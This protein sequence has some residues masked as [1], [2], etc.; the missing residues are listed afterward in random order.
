MSGRIRFGLYELD[1]DARELRKRGVLIRLQDQPFRVLA[2]LTARPGEIVTREEL[3]EQIWGKE[4]FVDFD[5]SL[6][7][8]VNRIREAL[9]DDANT[10]QY[11]ETVPRRGYRF[12][13]SVEGRGKDDVPIGQISA[14]TS[15]AIGYGTT[16]LE[17]EPPQT[18]TTVA[19]DVA[20][21]S[22]AVWRVAIVTIASILVA[23]LILGIW[24]VFPTP[25]PRIMKSMQLTNDGLPKCCPLVTDG[26]RI[27]FTEKDP[28]RVYS[29]IEQIQV[30]G[31]D[32]TAIPVPALK[33]SLG[34]NDIS[35]DRDRLLVAA[36]ISGMEVALWSVPVSG[37]SPRAL[38]DVPGGPGFN[39]GRWS[40]DG[41]RLVY[42]NGADLNVAQSD[43]SEP[44]RLV[45]VKGAVSDPVWSPD[46][47]SVRF[48]AKE[49]ET[50]DVGT[51][52]EVSAEGGEPREVTPG[53]QNKSSECAGN[54]T[55]DGKYF[56]FLTGCGRRTDIWAVREKRSFLNLRK[57][58]PIRLTVGPISYGSFAF[59]PDGKKIFVQGIELRGEVQRYDRKSAHF[60]T[61]HPALSADCCVY[62][63]D[64]QWIT[65]VTFPEQS[66]WRSRPDGTERQQLTWPPM[67]AQNPHWSPDGRE[68]AFSAHL[69]GKT[70]KTFIIAAE[71]GKPRELTLSECPE[72]DAN[73]SP[74][75]THLIFGTLIFVSVPSCPVVL[76]TL[77]LN[78]HKRSTVPGSEGLWSPRWSPDGKSIVA[79]NTNMHSLMLGEI[80]YGKWSELAR[81]SF[82]TV[83]FPQWSRDGSLIYYLDFFQNAMYSVRVKDHKIEKL[84]DLSGIPMTAAWG[85]WAAVAPDG[86]TLILRDVS[87]NEIYSFD[88]DGP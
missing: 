50:S 61:V 20:T 59:S 11:V 8:A 73:W 19:T 62:S 53:W 18:V 44:R 63:N 42:A 80:A 84:A 35:P 38:S 30:T 9:N 21:P 48:L 29:R 14:D 15:G 4:T 2:I 46:G 13:A 70:S 87:L 43:G 47:K 40:P 56:V 26:S 79:L 64:G 77:D 52:L 49:S 3:Q 68:I 67:N 45:T 37:S 36:G 5:Q 33:G 34:I 32:P 78:T 75:G 69:P 31:G 17:L 60:L 83:G 86:S 54:W 24:L 39:G 28:E 55:P 22:R 72:L 81:S 66:L 12:I 25:Q 41:Q 7:K 51:L 16:K 6:N 71:G 58:E 10:P 88:F 76:S 1:R 23:F 57:R 65:Y 74:D 85:S 27:Y 82:G